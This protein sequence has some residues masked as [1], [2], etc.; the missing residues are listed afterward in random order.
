MK[1][2]YF[3]MALAISGFTH[4]A[5]AADFDFNYG[6]GFFDPTTVSPVGG[7]LGTT[8]GE[9]R[10][11]LFAAAAAVLG[12]LIQSNVP[13]VVDAQFMPLNCSPTS[14]TLGSAGPTSF[15][16]NGALMGG[17][18][19]YPRSL[20]DA[21]MGINND[22]GQSDISA[23]FNSLI[24]SGSCLGGNT[25]YYGLDGLAPGG[26]VQ[27]FSVV[28]HELTHGLGFGSI[29]NPVDGS[30]PNFGGPDI[31][32]V[33]DLFIFDVEANQY[34][35]DMSNAQRLASTVNDPDVVWDGI[36]VTNI[37]S[38]FTSSGLRDG[39]LRLYAPGTFEPGSSIGHFTTAASP[40]LLM[41]PSLGN[42]AFDQ[43]DVTPFLFQ[44]MGY[45]I[46]DADNDGFADVIDNCID[47]ANSSQLDSN[48]DGFGNACDADLNNDMTINFTDLNQL[49]DV[50]FTNSNSP[51]WDPD[52]DFNG[53]GGCNFVDLDLMR[54]TFF[55]P[56]GPSGLV[57]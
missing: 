30:Y 34:W 20:E 40:D 45:S 3:L 12:D 37:A 10:Q 33:F 29:V 11:I 54:E 8:L 18:V 53:D 57:P 32:A 43:T 38:V 39:S 17:V 13:I 9:Q 51:N 28:L 42:I 36:N 44:D 27:I 7:N 25:F 24:D 47:Q 55:G 48:G 14:A 46:S 35:T 6:A 2:S 4:S 49:R 56:P 21:L 16:T 23:S 15:S 5:T 19:F 22:V 1:N 41:E 50:F 26:T 52:T 31:P